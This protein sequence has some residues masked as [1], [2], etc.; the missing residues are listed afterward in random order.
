MS[1]FKKNIFIVI[2]GILLAGGVL[3]FIG[4]KVEEHED[5]K[6]KDKEIAEGWESIKTPDELREQNP[7]Y[8]D[9]VEK[10][11]VDGK[12]LPRTK[13]TDGMIGVITSDTIGLR[14][15]I[16]MGASE[17]N[18]RRGVATVGADELLDGQTVSIAGHRASGD[19]YFTGI[20][21]LKAGDEVVI[22]S[23]GNDGEQLKETYVV[24][25]TYKVSPTDTSVMDERAGERKLILITCDEWNPTTKRYDKR[26]ITEATIKV[27]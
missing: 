16:F 25:K 5:K 18:M 8:D 14:E 17:M 1:W 19:K 7:S 23:K 26:W 2:G 27:G 10:S 11:V 15:P 4:E 12:E 21:R 24:D 20:L 3:L 9:N 22:E 6:V 13:A